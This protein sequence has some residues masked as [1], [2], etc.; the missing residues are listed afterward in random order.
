MKKSLLLII[1]IYFLKSFC[2]CLLE[3]NNN[4]ITIK[5]DSFFRGDEIGK[6]GILAFEIDYDAEKS[7]FDQLDIEENTTFIAIITNEKSEN[8]TIDC[9]LFQFQLEQNLKVF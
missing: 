9:N 8:N 3:E 7:L 2:F 5:I 4:T 1:Y 6:K